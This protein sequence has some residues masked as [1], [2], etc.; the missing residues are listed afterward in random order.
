MAT[1]SL[2][3]IRNFGGGVVNIATVD[4]LPQNTSPRGRNSIVDPISPTTA[5]VKKRN[6]FATYNDANGQAFAAEIN[7]QF[8]YIQTD[9]TKYHLLSGA[10]GQLGRISTSGVY[11]SV[12]TGLASGTAPDFAVAQ[13][14]CFFVNG[15]DRKK[16]RGTTL[17]E[18]GIEAPSTAP[19]IAQGAV[20]GNFDGTYEARVTFYN[21]NTTAESS[22][23]PTSTAVEI[24]SADIDV[25][26]IPV[27]ADAQVT[28]RKVYIRNTSTMANFFLAATIANNVDTTVTLTGSDTDLV[29]TGPDTDSNDRPPATVKYLTWHNNR[30]FAA[31]DSQLYYSNSE[32]PE[33]FDA[34]AVEPISPED[35]QKITGLAAIENVLIIFKER[36]MWGLF[37]F[38]PNEWVLRLISP[39]IGCTSFRSIISHEGEIYWWSREGLCKWSGSGPPRNLCDNAIGIGSDEWAFSRFD[40]VVVAGLPTED[41][42]VVGLTESG[43]SRNTRSLVFSGL[44]G[45]WVSD[46]WTGVE[47]ASIASIE[48]ASGERELF[49]GNYNG[50]VFKYSGTNDG[51]VG[52]TDTGTF[53]ASGTSVSS[54]TGTGFYTTGQGLAD[55]Y[56]VIQD[57][58]GNLIGHERITSNTATALTLANAVTVTN[59][60][61]YTYYVG[62]PNFEWDTKEHDSD[63]PFVRKRYEFLFI[64]GKAESGVT[65]VAVLYGDHATAKTKTLT[66]STTAS[67]KT[68]F[69]LRK[70]MAFTGLTWK[71][72]IASRAPDEAFSLYE[73][74]VRMEV[75]GDNLS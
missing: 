62:G 61:T 37:G 33:A 74:A 5:I 20:S 75:L 22:A 32:E 19:T 52:G 59:G 41:L 55:R 35:G 51:V 66:F 43:G 56:V 54:I 15:T 39:T 63:A 30:M 12:T 49:L 31:D 7:N 64:Q 36:S 8:Q 69:N 67:G 44:L 14:L 9:G 29:T 18:F 24:S 72:R 47:P 6:G 38:S 21:A 70:R 48:N 40:G 68:A 53:V 26:A 23:G 16:L 3:A 65:G 10:T 28:G 27:S 42:I 4:T 34:E 50:Q 13:D 60:D 25:S 11:T 2:D 58:E 46:G 45:V 57:S 73:L 1:K 71:L 17:E